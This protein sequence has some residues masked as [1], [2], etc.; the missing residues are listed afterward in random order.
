MVRKLINRRATFSSAAIPTHATATA[1]HFPAKA[2]LIYLTDK[3]LMTGTWL[4]LEQF[5]VLFLATKIPAHLAP[6]SKGQMNNQSPL[7]ASLKKLRNSKANLSHLLSCKPL[8]LAP[9]WALTFWENS[10]SLLFQKS[11]K[12]QFA[13]LAASSPPTHLPSA[14]PPAPSL[15]FSSS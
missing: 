3:R 12:V 14:A 4:I 1:I 7:G 13:C 10:Q 11:T 2:R 5:W 9:F 6:F 15:L 8:W